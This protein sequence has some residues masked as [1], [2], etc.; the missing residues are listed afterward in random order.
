MLISS[1]TKHYFITISMKKSVCPIHSLILEIQPIQ[2]KQ[3]AVARVVIPTFDHAHL[4]KFQSTFNFREFV[5]TRKKSGNFTKILSYL[6]ILQSDLLMTFWPISQE[7]DFSRVWSLCRNIANNI[8]FRYS[9][10]LVNT[11]DQIFSI[12]S[13]NPIF[14]PFSQFCWQNNFL[15]NLAV[16]HNFTWFSRITPKFREN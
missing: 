9:T 13:E 4:K 1:L 7:P 15:K 6:K 11:N 12:N 3:S 14:G 8:N 16:T 10:N 5:S 2:P